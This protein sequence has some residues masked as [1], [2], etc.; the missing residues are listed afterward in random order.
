MAL[1]ADAARTFATLTQHALW[2]AWGHSHVVVDGLL[3]TGFTG[4]V[5]PTLAALMEEVNHRTNH[6][7]R[8]FVLALD[9]PSG[10]DA[11]SGVPSPL[12]LR[13]DA[14]VTFQAAKPGLY[15]PSAH[16][17]TGRVH[18]VDIGIPPCVQEAASPAF[19]LLDV[20]HGN[21]PACM[22][23]LDPIAASKSYK[24][25]FGHV[26][27]LGGSTGL[28]GAAHLAARAALRSGAGL[29][30]VAAPAASCTDIR[31]GL[32]DIMTLP[33]HVPTAS[34][35][36]A[37]TAD[38]AWPDSLP[39]ALVE[40]MGRCTALVIGCGM[41]RT[42]DTA[43]F[44]HAVLTH[45]QRPPAIVDADALHSLPLHALT[46]HDVLTPHPGEAAALLR[47]NSVAIQ[48]DRAAAVRALC[49]L[50]PAT[51]VL[52]G[53]NTLIG[54]QGQSILISPYVVPN[55]AVGGTGDVLSGCAGA[56]MARKK[57]EHTGLEIAALAV[58]LHAEAGLC[59]AGG[60]PL[61]G[62]LASQVADALP[63]A[64][65]TLA[66]LAV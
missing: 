65:A 20:R 8:P 58:I 11:D 50:S 38:A 49:A 66:A 43:A 5:R 39:P 24:N 61:R 35:G 25:A 17:Y 56:L 22:G 60:Y 19:R 9:I 64:L 57:K 47:T 63:D 23:A 51:W 44:L 26:L 7:T 55:L 33:L 16:P 54:Q 29:V 1:G 14:T 15:M 59:L 52:K 12:A 45:P 34:G 36:N 4:P 37:K 27:V 18:T 3:G 32:P 6:D 48:S 30:S 2:G 28:A 42:P 46:V 41:G 13:A 21:G 40:L 62:N 10:L 53:A 31:A